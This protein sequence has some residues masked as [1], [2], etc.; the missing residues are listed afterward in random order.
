M[1]ITGF[2]NFEQIYQNTNNLNNYKSIFTI[3]E[4]L[5]TILQN[6][7]PDNIKPNCRVGA[8]DRKKSI[9]IVYLQNQE[10]LHLIKGFGERILQN[11]NKE[12]FSFDNIL[13]K[14]RPNNFKANV[15]QDT[16]EIDF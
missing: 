8:F 15:A 11:F 7:V 9:V 2:K 3:L 12:N 6:T 10:C 13:F 14:T 1:K 16:K 4:K 5:N